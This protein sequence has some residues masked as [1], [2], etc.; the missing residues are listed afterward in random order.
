MMEAIVSDNVAALRA[1]VTAGT[2]DLDHKFGRAER[3]MLHVAASFGAR[4]CMLY[5]AG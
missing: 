2:I 4:N 3:S 5:V 1:L